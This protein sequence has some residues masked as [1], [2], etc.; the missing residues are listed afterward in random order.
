M[1][2]NKR[3][4]ITEVR[5]ADKNETLV[6]FAGDIPVQK[7]EY[8]LKDARGEEFP[9]TEKYIKDNYVKIKVDVE[10]MKLGYEEMAEINLEEANAAIHTY[11]DGL[12]K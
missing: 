11:N 10:K 3:F 2:A 6:T 5:K 8:I 12:F 9:A 4:L 7:G 1:L